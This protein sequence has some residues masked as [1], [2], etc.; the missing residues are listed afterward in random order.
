[1]TPLDYSSARRLLRR[2]PVMAPLIRE[3]GPCGLAGALRVDHLPA[4]VRAIVFFQQLSTKTA[5]TIHRRLI[6]LLPGGQ[7]SAPALAA[8][9]D[10]PFNDGA[11][12]P[13]SRP[14]TP[15]KRSK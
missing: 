11:V 10:D 6:G 12:R 13:A 9:T 1:V 4:L 2:D 3:H 7:V 15:G 5:A 8:L 14:K